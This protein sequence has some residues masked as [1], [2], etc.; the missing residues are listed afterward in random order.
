MFR[1]VI[2]MLILFKK[3]K[4]E[5]ITNLFNKHLLNTFHVSFGDGLHTRRVKNEKQAGYIS[6]QERKKVIP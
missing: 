5:S 6:I 4:T 1:D 2:G 3:K